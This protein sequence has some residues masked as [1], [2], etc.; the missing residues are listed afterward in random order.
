[1]YTA[2][3]I[4]LSFGFMALSGGAVMADYSVKLFF[5]HHAQQFQDFFVAQRLQQ[6]R[7]SPYLYEGDFSYEQ[8]FFSQF[9]ASKDSALAVL[10]D[11][12]KV[13]GA[14]NGYAFSDFIKNCDDVNIKNIAS[15]LSH[16]NLDSNTCYY[17]PDVLILPE[18][19]NDEVCEKLF[20]ILEHHAKTLGYTIGIFI[21]SS[22]NPE[23]DDE[24]D[25]AAFGYQKT[26]MSATISWNTMQP[27]GSLQDQEHTLFFWIKNL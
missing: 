21:E 24:Y 3:K 8:K 23:Q 22:S 26:V 14:L 12:D 10:Y 25:Y 16:Y 13:V 5:G 1:M 27:D 11:Q 7:K 9:I 2:F 20:S 4:T 17:F 6:Y 15:D 19:K 18:H